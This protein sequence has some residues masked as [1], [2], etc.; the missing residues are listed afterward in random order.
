MRLSQG[1][2]QAAAFFDQPANPAWPGSF[3]PI[4]LAGSAMAM[5]SE[6]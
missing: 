2:L 3:D 5:Q 1:R 4:A 6:A